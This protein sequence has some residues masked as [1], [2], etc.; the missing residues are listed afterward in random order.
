VPIGGLLAGCVLL[1][2]HGEPALAYMRATAHAL[3]QPQ[4]YIGAVFGARPVTREPGPGALG[5]ATP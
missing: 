5:R 1:V 4:H 2:L 3:H